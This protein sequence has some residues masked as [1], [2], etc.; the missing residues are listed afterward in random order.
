MQRSCGGRKQR[1]QEDMAKLWGWR[2]EREGVMRNE[3]E[4]GQGSR[5]APVAEI[6]S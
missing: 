5:C 2:T 1:T 4:M 3:A 6:I